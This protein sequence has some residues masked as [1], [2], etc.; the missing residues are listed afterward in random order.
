MKI[1]ECKEIDYCTCSILSLD[2]K[3][4]CPQHG[5]CNETWPPKCAECGRFISQKLNDS[6]NYI[7]K[8]KI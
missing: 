4:T 1:H 5:G 7:N 2:P 3:E 8:N 6:S